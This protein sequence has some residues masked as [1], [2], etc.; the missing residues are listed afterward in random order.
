M[1]KLFILLLFIPLFSFSQI[2]FQK[3]PKD[4]QLFPR[5]EN[6]NSHVVFSGNISENSEDLKLKL[7]VFKDDILINE[8]SLEIIDKKFKSTSTIKAGLHQYK[9]ELYKKVGKNESLLY[10]AINIVCGD[11]YIIT[12]QSN[13]HA[14]SEKSI[15]SSRFARSFGV[16]TGYETYSDKDKM[17]GWGLATGNCKNCEGNWDNGYG[18]G[19]F[20]NNPHSVGVWGWN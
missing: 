10:K 20:V 13:S 9:F 3:V 18:G 4:F 16:K 7:K 5:D 2:N 12:G 8:K 14:S 11:A 15:Y 1:K 17:V 19:W 6:N